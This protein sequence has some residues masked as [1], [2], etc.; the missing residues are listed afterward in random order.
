MDSYMDP[1]MDPYL[2]PY[3]D[4]YMDTGLKSTRS[5]KEARME[6]R[7]QTSLE[8]QRHAA[9]V[10]CRGSEQSRDLGKP[11]HKGIGRGA[12]REAGNGVPDEEMMW[13][14]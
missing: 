9:P 8:R 13:A 1:Y 10:R 2:D 6:L 7:I 14:C 11:C 3:M 4:P 12:K 5:A